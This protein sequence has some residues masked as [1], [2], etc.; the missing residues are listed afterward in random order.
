MSSQTKMVL[1]II[2]LVFFGAFWLDLTRKEIRKKEKEIEGLKGLIIPKLEIIEG[3]TG[4]VMAR[5][6]VAEVSRETL[7]LVMKQQL[8]SLQREFSLNF[9]R[10]E[11]YQRIQTLT[12]RKERIRA[13]DTFFLVQIPGML[14]DS[15]PARLFRSGDRF[16]QRSDTLMG[17]TLRTG[18]QFRQDLQ[19]AIRK[20]KR[21]K[22]WQ[23]WKKRPLRGE[24]FTS[25]SATEI[26]DFQILKV[27]DK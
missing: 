13:K 9:K 15:V 24:L 4:R 22:W 12:S 1:A 21:Q 17:D 25:D 8:D 20:G 3:N 16:F 19:V 7:H 14:P 2:A 26:K 5:V 27:I 6:P 23:L 11:Q 10:I 18:V